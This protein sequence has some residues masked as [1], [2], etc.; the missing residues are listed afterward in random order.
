[1]APYTE[2]LLSWKVVEK[3]IRKLIEEDKYL[4]P[5]GKEAYA[6]YKEEQ[7]QKALEKAQAKMERETKVACKDAIERAIAE[8]FDGMRLPKETAEEVI[9][10]YGIE[11]VS[12]VLAN[13]IMHKNQDGRFSPDNKEW[14]KEIEPYAMWENRDMVVDSHPAV[15]NGFINQTRRYINREQERLQAE[16][17]IDRHEAEVFAR[18]EGSE[19]MEPDVSEPEE[20]VDTPLEPD[21]Q[22]PVKEPEP[23][24]DKSGAENFHITDDALGAGSAKEKF[25]R[26][27]AAIVA[28]ADPET[29]PHISP[30]TSLQIELTRS[31]LL[32]RRIAS[33]LPGTL[34]AAIE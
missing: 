34:R 15:L 7:A 27:W 8:K 26:T 28:D 1:M 23:Q 25:C 3:R 4:S 21:I 22:M 14:A 16:R 11:R 12:Y 29:T 19:D 2:V 30:T 33:A 31:A 10:E 6:Q 17:D 5:E 13:T 32:K 9:R 20:T 24:I 18:F